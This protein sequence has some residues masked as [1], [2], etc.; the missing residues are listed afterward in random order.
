MG[1]F[2]R[3]DH[4]IWS[5]LWKWA[6]R[7]HTNKSS[8]W[9]MKKYFKTRGSRKGVFVA[10][11]ENGNGGELRLVVAADTKIRRHVN[12]RSGANPHDPAWAQY[13]TVLRKQIGKFATAV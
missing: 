4:E 9:A 8:S 12:I 5:M 6:K 11:E 10:A 2:A 3:N 1:V 13:F 7:R